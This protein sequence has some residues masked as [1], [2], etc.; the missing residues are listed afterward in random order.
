MFSHTRFLGANVKKV[1]DAGFSTKKEMEVFI[2]CT[3]DWSPMHSF[4]ARYFS[5]IIISWRLIICQVLVSYW[6]M[7]FFSFIISS[8]IFS[9]IVLISPS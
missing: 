7:F 9:L 4:A 8:Q 6:W 3:L 2:W 1:N 5:Y